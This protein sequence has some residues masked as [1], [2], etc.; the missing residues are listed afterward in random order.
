MTGEISAYQN[1]PVKQLLSKCPKQKGVLVWHEMGTGKT[2]TGLSMIAALKNLRIIVILPKSLID[3]WFAEGRKHG[4]DLQRLVNQH[5]LKF[6]SYEAE[7]YHDPGSFDTLF[8]LRRRRAPEKY[9]VIVDEAHNLIDVIKK[10]QSHRG[11]QMIEW[12]S[13]F[14]K[15][16]LLTGTPI[17]NEDSDLRFLVNIAA[18]R[19]VLPYSAENFHKEFFV[20]DKVRS[21][22]FGWVLTFFEKSLYQLRDVLALEQEIRDSHSAFKTFKDF[23]KGGL[24]YLLNGTPFV[25]VTLANIVAVFVPVVILQFARIINASQ[26]SKLTSIDVDKFC[27]ATQP[28]ISFYDVPKNV[29]GIDYPTVKYK[30]ESCDY[31]VQQID[32]WIRFTMGQL[33]GHERVLVGLGKG[34]KEAEIFGDVSTF[35]QFC[36]HGL[37]IGNLSL[38]DGDTL[39]ESPKF[40]KILHKMRQP[41]GTLESTVIYSSYLQKGAMMFAA[42]LRRRHVSY[43]VLSPTSR[44]SLK[45]TY[46]EQFRLQKVKVLILHPSYTEGL[47]IQGAR[48]MHILEPI[49][50]VARRDQIVARVNRLKSHHHLPEDQRNVQVYQWYCTAD[51]L[52][53]SISKFDTQISNWWKTHREVGYWAYQPK[54]MQNLTP[55]SIVM[56]KAR[57]NDTLVFNLKKALTTSSLQQ[58]SRNKDT[59]KLPIEN[60]REISELPTCSQF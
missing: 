50:N 33:E 56:Q 54:F 20:T 23:F 18:G 41:D 22:A 36:H 37:V 1:V 28:Y 59:C 4:V 57:M 6:V 35:E 21:F 30:E 51:N 7:E 13:K 45:T 48:Q 31:N 39:H 34:A 17:Y 19:I 16:L 12:L 25:G 38:P 27:K 29:R 42:F 40:E 32:I 2:L 11:T 60:D 26:M 8:R 24:L 53:S 44:A 43:H 3:V 15:I 58:Y 52:A 14:S 46:L 5:R 9:A 47:T 49:A 10:A 55:D